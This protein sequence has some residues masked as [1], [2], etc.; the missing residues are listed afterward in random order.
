M[1]EEVCEHCM[2]PDLRDNLINDLC[3]VDQ[4]SKGTSGRIRPLIRCKHSKESIDL[5]QNDF[6]I[7]LTLV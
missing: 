6:L 5:S 1:A 3:A 7:L 4:L 2:F